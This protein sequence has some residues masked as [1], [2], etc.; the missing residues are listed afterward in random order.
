MADVR[1]RAWPP[2]PYRARCCFPRPAN[3]A[4][5][6]DPIF[7]AAALIAVLF[8]GLG[9]GGFSGVG[10]VAT[11]LLALTIPPVQAAAIL[12]PILLL[13]DLISVWAY[14]F[15]W[16]NWNL[17]VLLPGSVLGV[18]G[19]W[20]FAAQV[21]DS[22]LRVALGAISLYFVLSAWIGRANKTARRPGILSGLVWGAG[23]GF[24]STISH[25]GAPPFYMHVL[26]QRL[27]RITFAATSAIFFAL[28]NVMKLAPFFSLG[29]FSIDNLFISALL[30]PIA[31][32]TNFLG[33]WLVRVTPNEVF[34]RIVYVIVFAIGLE[35]MR[36][37]VMGIWANA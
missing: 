35:L 1:P 15:K 30:A 2:Q 25:A 36:N 8:L 6:T 37:G 18:A 28:V 7:I 34:Y 12:L 5:P 33:I 21:S 14:R 32:A 27:D 13:Q 9:K 16:D 19:G 10:M 4:V 3:S 22:H 11:P 24:T 17:K 26:P 20:A 23:C 29:Q 31:I